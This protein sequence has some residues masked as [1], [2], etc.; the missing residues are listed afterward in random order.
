MAT[1]TN[2]IADV[3]T[4]NTTAYVVTTFTP[5]LN[6]LL[7]VLVAT[8]G[9]VEPTAAGSV[10]DDRGGTYYKAGFANRS[11]TASVYIF[12]RNQL[13]ASAVGHILTFTCGG[14]AATGC[15]ILVYR[16]SGMTRAGSI[17][18]KQIATQSNL[19]AG[20]TPTVTFGSACLT[21]NPVIG[22]VGSSVNPVTVT[23]PSGFTEPAGFDTGTTTPTQSIEGCHINS[24]FTSTT[25]TWGSTSAGSSGSVAVE[26]DTTLP[27]IGGRQAVKIRNQA[28]KRASIF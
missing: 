16:V 22:T 2:A 21:S 24:G 3:D 25:V 8:S 20:G 5:A 23:P 12:V 18:V 19:G 6:D 9:S 1:C 7:V 15:C 10:S 13:V 28:V 14:D 4:S 26:L 11:G 17:A 27:P